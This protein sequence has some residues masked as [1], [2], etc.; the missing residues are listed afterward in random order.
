MQ[1]SSIL[2]SPGLCMS[3]ACPRTIWCLVWAFRKGR[4]ILSFGLTLLFG[5]NYNVFQII[6][7]IFIVVR[8][9]GHIVRSI[10]QILWFLW[11]TISKFL[12]KEHAKHFGLGTFNFFR[13]LFSFRNKIYIFWACKDC[14]VDCNWNILSGRSFAVCCG[15]FTSTRAPCYVQ[16]VQKK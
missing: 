10:H 12:R 6:D 8:L 4:S 2:F 16:Y 15:A 1:V 13:F 3:M 14:A 7:A 9:K 11:E 5:Q